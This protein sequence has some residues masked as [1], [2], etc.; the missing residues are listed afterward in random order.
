MDLFHNLPGIY[1][2]QIVATLE[3]NM[4]STNASDSPLFMVNKKKSPLVMFS[5]RCSSGYRVTTSTGVGLSR[6][7]KGE[8]LPELP[9]SG[10]SAVTTSQGKLPTIGN[11]FSTHDVKRIS[12]VCDGLQIFKT[13]MTRTVEHQ[14]TYIRVL[15]ESTRKNAMDI[16]VSTET[17]RNSL[18]N[19]SLQLN[20]VEADLLDT[21]AA[22]IKQARY[23][24]AIREIELALQELKLSIMQ[25]QEAIDVTS[26]GQ[27]SSVLINPYNLSM[28][29]QQVSL[30][31]LAGLS[32]LTGLSVQD[33]YVY[34]TIAVVHAV[35]T[36]K[37]IRLF[38]EI[39]LKAS[40]R[41][42]E[43]YQGHSLTFFHK[44]VGKFVMV[45][46]T[47]TYLAV[48]ESRQF[49]AIITP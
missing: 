41:Y 6:T 33:M 16:T 26:L 25:L 19:F 21:Q 2:V 40:D 7:G 43:L 48:A 14:L 28:I 31:L 8:C 38:I 15:D 9:G 49:F 3:V 34:Y 12:D 27:L 13:K 11:S 1:L 39:P 32:M 20:R 29:L 4:S 44:E 17:L 35:A 47:F 42:F 22:L 30:Q 18:Y 10:L 45:D 46:E 24:A 37:S 5:P 23:S 36:S